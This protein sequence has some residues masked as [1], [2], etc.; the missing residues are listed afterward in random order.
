MISDEVLFDQDEFSSVKDSLSPEELE[1][2]ELTSSINGVDDSVSSDSS[3]SS[4]KSPQSWRQVEINQQ[5]QFGWTPENAE[6]FVDGWVSVKKY[7]GIG[8][9]KDFSRDDYEKGDEVLV[10][11][12]T[13]LMIKFR[14][15]VPTDAILARAKAV[16]L[17][18]DCIKVNCLEKIKSWKGALNYLTH[19]DCHLPYKHI[20]DPSEVFSD[21]DWQAEC[22]GYHVEQGIKPTRLREKE[23][24]DAI[25]RGDIKEYDLLDHMMPYEVVQ[26]DSAICKSFKY[27]ARVNMQNE[28]S[29]QVI[30]ISGPSRIGKDTFAIEWCK[31]R[32]FA[33]Y[34]TNNNPEH[35]FDNYQGQ[36]VIIW[37]DARDDIFKPHSLHQLLDNHYSSMQESRYHDKY[38]AAKYL[39]I[40]SIKPLDEWYTNFYSKEREDKTQLYARIAINIDIQDSYLLYY[41]YNLST[42]TYDYTGKT[43][44]VYKHD[45]DYVDTPDKQSAL[46]ES[47]L[48]DISSDFVSASN[49]PNRPDKFVPNNPFC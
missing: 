34:R 28:R 49:D 14:S 21:F 31:K 29:M 48:G 36:P 43:P 19:R 11:P 6:K 24:V 47:F 42:K 15:P 16:G 7:A 25:F 13:H 22:E 5:W 44:N 37:S 45:E 23:I 17:P 33:Y 35:P 1:L 41:T 4:D 40:T 12:H 38:I 39:L 46:V 27:L 10:A 8:H 3:D 26:Y 32:G 2:V 9:D 30:F 20:Y 18:D